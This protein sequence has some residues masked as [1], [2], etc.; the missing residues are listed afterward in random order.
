MRSRCLG[1]RIS[2]TYRH[3]KFSLFDEMEE[4]CTTGQEGLSCSDMM[5]G[6]G[7]GDQ[8]TLWQREQVYRW[9]RFDGLSIVS[10]CAM[11]PKHGKRTGK[12]ISTHPIVDHC[13]SL[14]AGNARDFIYEVTTICDDYVISSGSACN[15]GFFGTGNASDH[16]ATTGF[17]ELSEHQT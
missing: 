7:I 2:T 16:A 1:E 8:D 6:C 3:M 13:N 12:G 11:V 9:K 15:L 10:Q 17:D 4:F 5:K 14:T